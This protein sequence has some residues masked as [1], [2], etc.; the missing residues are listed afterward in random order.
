MADPNFF[1]RAGPFRLSD[2]AT[3]SGTDLASV[4]D[5]VRM[6]HEVG[7]LDKADETTISFFESAKYI[8]DLTGSKAGFCVLRE[9]H[10][11]KAPGHMSLL[12]SNA[13]QKA[14]ALI[15]AA[16]YPEP[17]APVGVDARAHVDASAAVDPTASIAPGAV[18]GEG[19]QI[20]PKTRVGAN[21]VIGDNVR[22]GANCRISSNCSLSYCLIADG[23]AIDAGVRI[24]ERGFGFVIDPKGHASI[25]Q[26]GRVI[27]EE[28]VSIGANTTID[29]G[30]GPDTV[31]RKGAIID[32]QV[33]IGHNVEVGESSV[34]VSQVGIAGST[35][36]GPMVM[37][38]GK[39]G[40]AG[41][42]TIGAGAQVMAKSGLYKDVPPGVV[43]A[44][45]PALP[46][47]EYWRL[48]AQLMK[49][50]ERK[51]DKT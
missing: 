19:V 39:V 10:A 28:G 31:I 26:L 27:L 15:A 18:I 42:L 13:P 34:L 46:A 45:L 5:G 40:I 35:K 21:T 2:L 29:R 44:G 51:G 50:I 30:A 22:I 12:I 1:K 32:N 24:G 38:G 49:L 47:R 4:D 36:L 7:S 37:L 48:Q 9:A 3:I 14:Y 20:G 41:H 17:A 8:D 43:M 6:V 25:P 33:Q 16:F 23:V 11:A